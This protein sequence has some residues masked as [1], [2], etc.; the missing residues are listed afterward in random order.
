MYSEVV[1]FSRRNGDVHELIDVYRLYLYCKSVAQWVLRQRWV[2]V[3]W[4]FGGA[5]LSISSDWRG[6]RLFAIVYVKS[7]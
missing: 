7:L 3:D 4:C 1:V 5:N 6:G 2:V